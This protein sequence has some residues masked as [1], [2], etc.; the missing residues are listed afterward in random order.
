MHTLLESIV[1]VWMIG[2]AVVWGPLYV[3]G[4]RLR[5]RGVFGARMFELLQ[6]IE[7]FHSRSIQLS[8][9]FQILCEARL[10]PSGDHLARTPCY[11]GQ[12]FRS[13]N[14]CLIR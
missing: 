10:C 14:V 13:P 6:S 3:L 8:T 9:I 4:S 11:K 12:V 5:S 1:L 7:F 2:N